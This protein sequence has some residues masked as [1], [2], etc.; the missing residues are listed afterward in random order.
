MNLKDVEN[1]DW[2]DPIK[3]REVAFALLMSDPSMGP[4]EKAQIVAAM[5]LVKAMEDFKPIKPDEK[6]REWPPKNVSDILD[7]ECGGSCSCND[8]Y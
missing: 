4:M 5:K 6:P 3:R 2:N 8:N 7:D 1:T